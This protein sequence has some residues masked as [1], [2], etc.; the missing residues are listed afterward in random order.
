MP[1]GYPFKPEFEVS[2]RRL[3]ERM[4]SDTPVLL[5]DVRAPY[6]HEFCSLAPSILI[7]MHEIEDRLDEL[8]DELDDAGE[9]AELV[10][11]CHT[12]V[13]SLKIALA[14]RAHGFEGA[15]SLAGGVELW[16]HAIDPTLPRYQ[17]DGVRCYPAPPPGV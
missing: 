11:Y 14:L 16:S 17:K 5:V 2:P 9:H 7:P 4:E 12:G 10:L 13:R 3:A 1:K 15:V 8:R 6:E